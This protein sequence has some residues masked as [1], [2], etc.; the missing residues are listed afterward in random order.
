M[1]ESG[2]RWK[3]W[4]QRESNK[5]IFVLK[6]EKELIMW[7]G[8]DSGQ[9]LIYLCQLSGNKAERR[10]PGLVQH[11]AAARRL[12]NWCETALALRA[13][14]PIPITIV[15]ADTGR[16]AAAAVRPPSPLSPLPLL[17]SARRGIFQLNSK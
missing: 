12:E 3:K 1:K 13:G 11:V 8:R 17:S 2:V 15:M 4:S 6:D 7:T 14:I 16:S 9:R 5:E 10:A